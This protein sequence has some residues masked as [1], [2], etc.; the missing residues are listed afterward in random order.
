M[1][2]VLFAYRT[3]QQASTKYTPFFLMQGLEVRL[4]IDVEISIGETLTP[5]LFLLGIRMT[6]KVQTTPFISFFYNLQLPFSSSYM[7]FH[8]KLTGW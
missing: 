4:P 7:F 5:A 6:I 8:S 1:D 2:E 3:S